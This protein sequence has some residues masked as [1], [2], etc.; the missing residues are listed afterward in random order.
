M[1]ALKRGLLSSSVYAGAAFAAAM[2]IAPLVRAQD[3]PE[4]QD[5]PQEEQQSEVEEI[6]V[7]GSRIPRPNQTSP[8]AV[9][10]VTT[11]YIEQTGSINTGD[12]VRTLPATGVSSITP[13]NS[14]FATT[15]NAIT[16]VDLR[17]LGEDRTLTLVNGRRFVPGVVG[18]QAVD[19]STIPTGLV[20]RIDVITGG[21]SAVYGSDALAGVVNILT[22]NDF[23]GFQLN[24]Q[25]G[26]SDRGDGVEWKVAALAGSQFQDGRGHAVV[27]LGYDHV[28]PIRARSRGDQGMAFDAVNAVTRSGDP[29]DLKG[30]TNLFSSFIPEGRFLIPVP[31][32]VTTPD[33]PVVLTENDTGVFTDAGIFPYSSAAFGFNRQEFRLLQVP[34]NR[35]STWAEFAYDITDNMRFFS[36]LAYI[37]TEAESQIEPTPL[38]SDQVYFN[39]AGFGALPTCADDNGDGVV[40]AC[41]F[42]IPLTSA[43]VPGDIKDLVRAANPGLADEDLVVG[44]ARRTPEVG[45][46]GNDINRDTFRVVFG[47]EGDP[48]ENIHYEVSMNYGRTDDDQTSTGDINTDRLRAALDTVVDPATGQIVCSDINFRAQGCV[49]INIFGENSIS[50]AA[51]DFIR[52]Q[53]SRD[54]AIEEWVINGFVTGHAWE[55]PAGALEWVAGSEYRQEKSRDI[56]DPLTQAGATS[57]N[58]TPA[59]I[60]EFNVY[61][62]FG[63]LRIPLLADMAWAQ[64]LDLNLAGRWSEYS[65]VGWTQAYAASLEWQATDWA[66]FRGQYSKAVRAPN[67]SELFQPAQQ[68]FPS[69]SDPC[70]GVTVTAGGQAAFLNV[71]QDSENPSNVLSSGVD[72]T[73]IGDPIAAACLAD[74]ALAARVAATGGFSQT[75]FEL[76][77]V[78]GFDTGNPDLAAETGKSWTFGVIFNPK[79]NDWLA[80][81]SMSIDYY[82]IKIDNR[83][84]AI[85]EQDLLNN[86]YGGAGGFDPTNLF[87]SSIVR[88]NS[89]PTIGALQFV[90]QTQNNVAETT[91]KGIDVQASYTFQFNDYFESSTDWGSLLATWNYTW[92]DELETVPF[93]G[94]DPIDLKG[95]V[96]APENQWLLNLVYSR[97]KLTVA[98]TTQY[99]GKV[100]ITNNSDDIFF[101]AEIGERAFSDMQVRYDFNDQSTLFL[102]V[103]NIFDEYVF[104][105]GTDG[106][107]GQA[108]GWTTFPDVYDGVGRF[109]YAGVKLQY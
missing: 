99:I 46:R 8:T 103:D 71:R 58:A 90:N 9:Q 6:V 96:G 108:T 62:F 72:P 13:T 43:S 98:W 54:S 32:V 88:F 70:A 45:N 64:S 41:R 4:Q 85:D 106:G 75:Q 33:G 2:T 82:D 81:L 78:S 10:V 56:P 12:I 20:D 3:L 73:T 28:G 84:Q 104:V 67:I 65:T 86:C 93:A 76:Q 61:E 47:V 25:Y 5:Q 42:G 49:P 30:Q 36:E 19:Y 34:S 44:F 29:N 105:G 35:I 69:V 87:C 22:R 53:T 77:G 94:A 50:P 68:D 7:T 11:Q 31:T 59:T 26:I 51:A 17:N 92:V 1:T 57:G 27:N 63:E 14:G 52:A 83:I 18:T 66:K 102:G 15:G 109:Y 21:A 24:G 89:G 23:E 40:D 100:K 97:D 16:T 74:P 91:A 79:F 60:G 37:R 107:A 101:G 39:E 55:L 48:V 80:P 38:G 95:T